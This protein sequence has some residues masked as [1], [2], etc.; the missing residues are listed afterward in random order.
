MMLLKSLCLLLV[1]CTQINSI[2]HFCVRSENKVTVNFMNRDGEKITVKAPLGDSLL[3]V[4]VQQELDID[5][6]G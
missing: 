1:P 4:V 2:F 6:F 3:D 5:G